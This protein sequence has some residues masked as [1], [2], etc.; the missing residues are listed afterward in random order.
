MKKVFVLLFLFLFPLNVSAYSA[1]NIIAMDMD[2]KRVLY[3]SNANDA[4]LIASISKIMTCILALELSDVESEVIPSNTIL[5][6]FGSGIYIEVGEKIKLK[7]LLYGLMLRS[8][9]DA[10]LAIAEYVGGNVENFVKLMN[11]KAKSIGM[12]NTN[13]INPH[14][15]ENKDGVGNTSTAYDMALLSSYAMQNETY[16]EIV[17]TKQYVA[18]SSTKTYSWMNKNKMLKTYEYATGGKTGFTEKA[19][20]TLVSTASKDHKNITIVTLN[21]P[22]DWDDHKSL[23]ETLFRAYDSVKV[24]GKDD[25]KI[26]KETYYKNDTLYIKEDIYVM[27]KENEKEDISIAYELDKRKEYQNNDVVGKV[28]I[29]LKDQVVREE[30]IFVAKKEEEIKK[31]SWWQKIIGWFKHD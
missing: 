13:F 23:Y 10:A 17:G 11:E 15:L 3:E 5:K 2:S 1:R 20:R 7:D 19:R 26:D 18:K 28:K 21:D 31:Q 4:H 30:A 9:N 25:F 12:K 16:R 6:S 22:N 27:V 8:G 29:K 14:G 24:V